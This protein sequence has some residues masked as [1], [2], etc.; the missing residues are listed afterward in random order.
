MI[1]TLIRDEAR[2]QARR[3]LVIIGGCL[4][5]EAGLLLVWWVFASSTV[6]A[7]LC[8]GT[9][10]CVLIALPVLVAAALIIEYWSSMYGA[11]GYLTMSLPVRGRSLFAGKVAWA[12]ASML[13]TLLAFTVGLFGWMAAEAHQKHLRVSDLLA[14]LR[15]AVAQAG[16]WPAVFL[17][18]YIVVSVV[19]AVVQVAAVMSIGAQGRWN[20]LGVGA[21]VLGAVL[22]YVV[23]EVVSLAATLLIPLSLRVGVGSGAGHVEWRWMLPDFMESVRTHADITL[24]GLGSMATAPVLAALMAWWAVRSIEQHTSLR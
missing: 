13:L 10:M 4:L 24:L 7:G 14:P 9:A 21:P 2:T 11:R 20:H 12:V 18:A 6:I 23:N 1:G 3:L 16:A 15:H 8:A 19:I 17:A 5:V 22:L